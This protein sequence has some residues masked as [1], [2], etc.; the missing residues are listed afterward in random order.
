MLWF[1]GA[2]L[3]VALIVLVERLLISPEDQLSAEDLLAL[4]GSRIR[5][6]ARV[7][8]Y[9]I[10]YVDP[11][12][13]GATVEFFDGETRL[14]SSITDTRGFAV[15]E[16]DSGPIGRRRFRVK[17]PRAEEALVVDVLPADAPILAVD[18]DHTLA[19]ISTLRFAFTTNHKTRPLPDAVDI[20]R[21]LAK[22]FSIVYLT[23]RDHS[24][25]GKT[26]DWLRLQGLPDGPVMCRRRRFWSQRSYSHKLER[27]SE[28]KRT[29]RLAA[30]VGDLPTDAKAYLASGMAAY[31]MDPGAQLPEIEGAVRVRGWREFEERLSAISATSAK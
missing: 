3:L 7:E 22:R 10:R 11:A 31:L 28:L 24:F 13:R 8:R 4:P 15:L 20:L 29:H 30:G 6:V 25:L 23:A 27:L 21:R 9:V 26:R 18:I 17:T 1:L 2:L 16:T 5:L 19:D 14:G 12:V